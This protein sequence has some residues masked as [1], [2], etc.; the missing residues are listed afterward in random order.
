[1]GMPY[2]IYYLPVIWTLLTYYEKPKLP[3]PR[4]NASAVQQKLVLLLSM[5]VM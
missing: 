3:R 1:M 5:I 4:V 2:S